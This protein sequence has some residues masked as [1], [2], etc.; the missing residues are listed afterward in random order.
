VHEKRILGMMSYFECLK[1]NQTIK[2]SKPTSGFDR[3]RQTSSEA[4]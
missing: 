3:V 2:P 1:I 4:R